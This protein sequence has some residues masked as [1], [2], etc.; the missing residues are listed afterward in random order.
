[1]DWG[2]GD[3]SAEGAVK[4]EWGHG[5]ASAEGVVGEASA[6]SGGMSEYLPQGEAMGDKHFFSA[7]ATRDQEQLDMRKSEHQE[8]MDQVIPQHLSYAAVRPNKVTDKALREHFHLPLAEVAKKFGMCTTA[9]KKLCRRQGIM[10]WPHRAL[11][12]IEKKIAS[13]RAEAKFTNNQHS[14]ESI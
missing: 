3:V 8:S 13:L 1:M 5:D 2:R 12:S 9:F 4:M 10:N 14:S 6:F 7:E 11:R